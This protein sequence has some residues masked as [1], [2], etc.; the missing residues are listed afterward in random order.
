MEQS[1]EKEERPWAMACHLAAFVGFATA[2]GFVIGPLVVW[3]I[4]KDEYPLVDDQGKES[5]NFQISMLIYALL[6]L[7]SVMLG[8]GIPLAAL[9]AV[10]GF[11]LII[12]ASARA[13]KGERFRYPLTIRF[14]R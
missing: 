4:K 12:V 7:P 5:L 14:I 13:S 2:I 1:R 9:W 11:V 10:A 6:L 8:I 3:A